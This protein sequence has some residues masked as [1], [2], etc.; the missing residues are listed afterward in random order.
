M[1]APER[2][3]R[4]LAEWRRRPLAIDTSE[5]EVEAIPFS[6]ADVFEDV[7]DALAPSATAKGLEL[8]LHQPARVPVLLVGDPTRLRQVLYTL[9]R[10]AIEATARGAVALSVDSVRSQADGVRLTF[11]MRHAGGADLPS[12]GDVV[13][14]LGE[15]VSGT[16]SP[17]GFTLLFAL[18]SQAKPAAESVSDRFR[19]ALQG[20]RVLLVDDNAFNREIATT[21][22]ERGGIV[23]TTACDGH[24]ALDKLQHDD[25]DVVL[26]DCQ[27]PVLDGYATTRAL[28]ALPRFASLPVIAMTAETQTGDPG[29]ALDSGMNDQVAKPIDVAN[30]Y[31]TLARWVRRAPTSPDPAA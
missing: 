2:E 1:P 26:M 30:L 25:F 20:A 12:R 31:A 10:D 6:L 24:E 11:E 19:G 3:P 5:L 22:L 8:L 29:K 28:R 4:P 21:L 17:P 15:A 7:A 23:V 18:Q 9:G 13:Q 14:S 16:G 27:M